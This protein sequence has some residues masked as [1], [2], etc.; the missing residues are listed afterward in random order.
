VARKTARK[1]K[2]TQLPKGFQPIGG[3]GAS[4]PG[5]DTKVGE[6]IRGIV[7]EYDEVTVTR[8]G[9]KVQV[10]NLKLEA[11]DD[12]IYTVWQSAGNRALFDEDYTEIEV[13]IRYDG[14]GP[15]KRGRNPARLYS[16]AADLD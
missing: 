8:E 3:F 7:T 12:R 4:W 11:D 1:G 9:K 10:E 6:M 5:D 16:I 14:L 2:V 15:K 13:A